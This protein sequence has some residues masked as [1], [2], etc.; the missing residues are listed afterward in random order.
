MYEKDKRTVDDILIEDGVKIQ[1]PT[2]EEA[3]WRDLPADIRTVYEVVGENCEKPKPQSVDKQTSS[4]K[5]VYALLESWDAPIDPATPT[6]AEQDD[7]PDAEELVLYIENDGNLY[8]QQT[9]PIQKNLASKIMQGKYDHNLSIKL[10]MYL[11]DT[12]AKKYIKDV[13]D[14]KLT[15]DKIF[16]KPIRMQAAK[17][18][19]DTF[20]N[21]WNN[22]EF[23]LADL[24]IPK[25]YAKDEIPQIRE[26]IATHR[27]SNYKAEFKRL[28]DVIY[29]ALPSFG[30][31]VVK[32]EPLERTGQI[33][34]LG[35]AK[36]PIDGESCYTRLFILPSDLGGP[37]GEGNPNV[38][39]AKKNGIGLSRIFVWPASLGN[40]PDSLTR[41]KQAVAI[42]GMA[43]KRWERW[44]RGS[45]KNDRQSGP[46][47][48]FFKKVD[49]GLRTK[50]GALDA[51]TWE[52][53]REETLD[54]AR[55]ISDI[56]QEIN[57][58]WQNVNFAAEPY[59]QAMF[60]LGTIKDNYG[61]DSA[62]SVIAY[63]LANASTW[64]GPVAKKIKDE[65]K[66]MVRSG[67][68]REAVNEYNII[69]PEHFEC[70]FAVAIGHES[71]IEDNIRDRITDKHYTNDKS[72]QEALKKKW[73]TPE[74]NIT[75]K[76]WV[77]LNK[78][79]QKIERNAVAW[80]SKTFSGASD[81]GH[82]NDDLIGNVQVKHTDKKQ[83]KKFGGEFVNKGTYINR[84]GGMN[85][86]FGNRDF[87][88]F[89]KG[90]SGLAG[91]GINVEIEFFDVPEEAEEMMESI[92]GSSS[93]I[94]SE[95]F[96]NDTDNWFDALADE[97]PPENVKS[98][99]LKIANG[100]CTEAALSK[101]EAET[102]KVGSK[103]RKLLL[104]FIK[105]IRD[106]KYKSEFKN[107][108]GGKAG[109]TQGNSQ[110]SNFFDSLRQSLTYD[111]RRLR[112]GKEDRATLELPPDIFEEAN[113]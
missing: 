84:E 109:S 98:A 62:R 87:M 73:V 64:R 22:K 100:D 42:F 31:K 6:L 32:F 24:K 16:P 49:A 18:L 21:D 4:A 110:V 14:T 46:W 33:K 71:L 58:D 56:A 13:M 9:T 91:L 59:L 104:Q 37:E 105:N 92:E 80:L 10:W 38:G 85:S 66:K 89:M 108:F 102:K 93:N 1:K 26:D 5:D 25:K 112:E 2:Q 36:S 53:I 101:M 20:K 48:D 41:Y 19:A 88:A 39:P 70:G 77:Q 76:G 27:L 52:P 40:D 45:L 15:W 86:S 69:G 81:Q 78:D 3:R 63:F 65:L 23:N 83:M 94:F 43:G 113:K 30:I 44:S 68:L 107:Q 82:G 12:G 47:Q 50:V 103:P 111:D 61:A 95:G 97:V 72:V 99:M 28:S 90:T 7:M 55:K 74:G 17:M 106:N 8:R 51:G 96:S 29:K 54:E 11:V 60:K 34:I 67:R 79:I 57:N 35:Q 75:D